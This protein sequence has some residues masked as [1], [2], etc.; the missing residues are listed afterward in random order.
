MSK[1]HLSVLVLLMGWSGCKPASVSHNRSTGGRAQYYEMYLSGASEIQTKSHFYYALFNK[2]YE[3]KLDRLPLSGAVDSA[4][5]PYV[6]SWYP[7][8]LG[9]VSRDLGTGN[10]LQKYDAAFNNGQGLA[11]KWEKDNH[12][13]A[14]GSEASEWAG[15]CNGFS[16]AAQR[17]AEPKNSVSRGAVTFSPKDIKALLAEVHM[18]AKFYFMG[19]NRC[20]DGVVK[21]PSTRSD[22]F[23][24]NECDDV[25]PATFHVTV[26]N[27]IG[28]QKHT[29]I[30]D[31]HSDEQV[32]NYPH[33]KYESTVKSVD[34]SEAMR[35]ITGTAASTYRFN[36]EAV[37]Y[38]SVDLTLYH[39]P[40]YTNEYITATLK[41]SDRVKSKIYQYIL[42][43]D[44]AGR[45]IG[46]EWVGD[47]QKNHPDFLWV[48][49]EPTTGDGSAGGAN[50]HVQAAEVIKLWAESVGA[51]PLNP[52]LDFLEPL[53][54]SGWGRFPQFTV[55]I[56]GGSQGAVFLGRKQ[57]L[58]I[59]RFEG[60][61]GEMSLEVLLNGKPIAAQSVSAEDQL[62]VP[63]AIDVPG[64]HVLEFRWIKGGEL[65]DQKRAQIV[66]F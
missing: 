11:V 47:S 46:G 42:E 27:W 22:P 63:I 59:K 32:W 39:S 21:T 34:A 54:G 61:L 24:T 64:L 41:E 44:G 33:F 30:I 2:N 19:G 14:P 26:A 20:Q 40:A 62:N 65:L 57:A 37:S 12:T 7:Q 23:S 13:L 43:L 10:V 25:N 17:H 49:F 66:S 29:L 15:H 51:D 6:G 1:H 45:I 3:L 56:N 4:K 31:T 35:L 48:A 8:E 52:P 38:K 53:I 28:I 55:T 58:Q 50:P 5:I 60:L 18:G 36:P 9:G 16:A